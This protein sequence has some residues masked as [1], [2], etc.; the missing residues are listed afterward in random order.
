MAYE[1]QYTAET[2]PGRPC[3][4]E[5][6]HRVIRKGPKPYNG[7]HCWNCWNVSLW[8]LNDEG[9]YRAALECKRRP[10]KNG[11]PVTAAL[12]ALRWIESVMPGERTPDGARYTFKAVRAVMA[13]L[14]E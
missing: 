2:C 9:L 4:S 7:H 5:C 6:D 12:A 10:R 8:I 11:K 1:V 13:G 3:S 14:D